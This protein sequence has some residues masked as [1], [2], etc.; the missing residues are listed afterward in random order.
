MKSLD[1]RDRVTSEI[2]AWAAA[3]LGRPTAPRAIAGGGGT[4]RYFRLP[5]E[6]LMLMA[7]SDAA[8]NLAWLRLGRHLWFKGLPLPRIFDYDLKRGFFLLEDLGGRHLV[9]PVDPADSVEAELYYPLAVKSLARLHDEGLEGLEPAWC[10]QTRSYDAAMIKSQEIDLFLEQMLGRY[11]GLNKRL[12]SLERE[13]RA[14]A[15]LAAPEEAVRVLM[16]RDFQ[17]R[18]LMVH[19]DKVWLLDWQGARPG[20]A[21]YDLTSLLE[22][23]PINPLS[24]DFKQRLISLYLRSR[25][26][27]KPE[28]RRWRR[29]LTV[30]G[31]CR[32][33]QALGAFARLCLGGK[34][35]FRA[36]MAPASSALAARFQHPEL[37][38]FPRLAQAASEAAARL[39]DPEFRRP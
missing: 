25:R 15:A 36:Y 3:R 39:A 35:S 1:I 4:R 13:A 38:A 32:L 5:A 18:N 26:H 19:N 6:G 23:R 27:H 17:G 8:E 22:E 2:G 16:H 24:E 31:A 10:F 37:K 34:T 9:D 14:L 29:D 20:A 21:A 30:V 33:F 11:L 12:R 28:P 7:G